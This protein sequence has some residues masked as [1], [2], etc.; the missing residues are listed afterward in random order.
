[1]RAGWGRPD[2]LVEL[3]ASVLTAL[4]QPAFPH[5]VV[6]RSTPTAG[7]L[8][9]SNF[10][11]DL[12]AHPEPV[13]L[14]LYTRATAAFESEPPVEKEAALHRLLAPLLPVP[15]VFYATTDNPIT[16][17]PYMLRAWVEGERLE[18]V[19]HRLDPIELAALARDVGGVLAGIHRVTF[20]QQGF[21]NGSLEV[22]PFPPSL[23]VGGGLVEFLSSLLGKRGEERLGPDLF[24][25]LM[26]FAERTSDYAASW[27]GPPCLVHSDFG[28]S[29]I[30]VGPGEHG[31]RVVAVVDWEFA[32]SGSPFI[33]FGNLLRPPLGE[34]EGFGDSVARG[35]RAAGGVL[36]DDW[37]RRS[38]HSDLGA[39]SDFLSRP[40]IRP[41]LLADAR[42]VIARTLAEWPSI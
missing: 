13:L 39:W 6:V 8:A 32:F 10:R 1:M 15:G 2:N 37:R 36:P 31:P 40:K 30:L 14:R 27:S 4:I 42:R 28:G 19:A 35:Y 21:L 16:G 5:Q 11:L 20:S 3:E 38:L 26:A 25:S 24:A 7:G 22:K 41:G 34:L 17:H 29:N 12:S 23:G 33:D 18:V 9:N